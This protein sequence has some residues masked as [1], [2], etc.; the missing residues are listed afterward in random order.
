MTRYM[1]TSSCGV[2]E[3]Q[4]L[5]GLGSQARTGSL[6]IG[7]VAAVTAAWVSDLRLTNLAPSTQLQE[8]GHLFGNLKIHE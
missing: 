2:H 7:A 8:V 4:A 3:Y 1:F 5:E 6:L